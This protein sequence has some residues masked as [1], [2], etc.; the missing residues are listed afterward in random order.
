MFPLLSQLLGSSSP[1][2]TVN[3][4][5]LSIFAFSYFSFILPICPCYGLF[6]TFVK[7]KK[8]R[9]EGVKEERSHSSDNYQNNKPSL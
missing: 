3:H 2:E 6:S 1:M 7:G 8:H 4:S 9:G 5:S